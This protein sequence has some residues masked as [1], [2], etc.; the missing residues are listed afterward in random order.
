MQNDIE[1]KKIFFRNRHQDLAVE[2][3]TT[4]KIM[5]F[6]RKYGYSHFKLIPLQAHMEEKIASIQKTIELNILAAKK[7]TKTEEQVK[8]IKNNIKLQSARKVFYLEVYVFLRKLDDKKFKH[9]TKPVK[10][11]K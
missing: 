2:Y 8:L 7:P 9:I 4:V 6:I 5:E 1:A 3:N 11:R 10:F